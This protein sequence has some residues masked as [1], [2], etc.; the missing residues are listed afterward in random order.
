MVTSVHRVD[1]GWFFV[2]FRGILDWR[3]S[4]VGF[5]ATLLVHTLVLPLFERAS[6]PMFP[7]HGSS[8]LLG[9]LHLLPR[10]SA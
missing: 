8:W 2:H 1:H 5:I 10:V 7:A 3:R 6:L 4:R 9:L